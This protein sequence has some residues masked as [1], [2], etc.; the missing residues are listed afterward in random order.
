MVGATD[1]AAA[2]VTDDEEAVFDL[3]SVPTVGS[4]QCAEGR[5]D[6]SDKQRIPSWTDRILFRAKVEQS[7]SLLSYSASM[8]TNWSDHKPV[9]AVFQF[10]SGGTASAIRTSAVTRKLGCAIL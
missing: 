2:L 8:D 5:Y 4:V 7:L 1:T 3:P 9:Y 10:S 6:S